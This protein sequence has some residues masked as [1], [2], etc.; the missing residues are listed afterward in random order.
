MN[1][2]MLAQELI[3]LNW[4]AG[5]QTEVFERMAAILVEKGYVKDSFLPSILTREE[6]YPT[7]LPIEPYPVAI[8]HTDPAHIIKP[9]IAPI[10]LKNS[11]DWREMGNNDVIHQVQFIFMLGF[12][13]SEEHQGLLVTLVGNVQDSVMMT[14]LMNAKTAEEYFTALCDMKDMDD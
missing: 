1:K 7:A 9:F 4:E 6:N 14:R 10:R 8:P 5:N 12:L 13:K 11:V 3:Q 2:G